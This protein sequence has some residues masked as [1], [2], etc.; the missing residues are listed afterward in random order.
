MNF[1]AQPRPAETLRLVKSGGRRVA[2]R[3]WN[4]RPGTRQIDLPEDVKS[5]AR[6]QLLML[7][8]AAKAHRE[9]DWLLLLVCFWHGLRVSELVAFEKD[10]IKDG[11]LT[12]QRADG[13]NRTRHMLVE[14]PEPL[15]D[16]KDALAEFA[17]QADFGVPVF[18]VCRR[19]VDQLMKRYCAE[20]G[21]PAHLAH[22]QTLRHTVARLSVESGGIEHARRWLG[23]KSRTSIYECLKGTGE[24]AEEA[25]E[26]ESEKESA[27][28]LPF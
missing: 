11:Y 12:I 15:L 16:E 14:H 26:R 7:L 23:Y 24:E 1:W 18:N 3:K 20:V 19:R 4:T 21:I 2:I 13:S 9:R 5:L 25:V 22:A 17:E 27:D 10:A 6:P 28:A 8:A